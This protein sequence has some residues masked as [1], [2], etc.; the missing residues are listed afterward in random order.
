VIRVLAHCTIAVPS[1]FTPNA[2]GKNDFLFP[3]NALKADQLEFRVYNRM[4][5]IIFSGRDW[6]HKWD[7]RVNGLEQP[8]GIYAWILTYI[9]KETKQR[10]FQKGT[11]LLIR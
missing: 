2:D 1:A 4:G 7:G 11:S 10:I 5:Q 3:L 9:D 6:T 8:T